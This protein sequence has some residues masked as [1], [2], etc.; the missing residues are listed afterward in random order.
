MRKQFSFILSLVAMLS[1]LVACNSVPD[2]VIPQE[3][4]AQ[5]LADIHI[6]ESV[7]D[8]NSREYMSDSLKKTV[9]QSI[10]LKHDVTQAQLDTSFVWY[11]N[12]I[13]EYMKV[14][15]RVIEILNQRLEHTGGA[16]VAQSVVSIEGDSVDVWS[17][18]RYFSVTSKSPS[19]YLT[20][21]INSDTHWEKGDYYTW[22]VKLLNNMSPI[23]CAMAVDY[24][25]GSTDYTY[26]LVSSEGWNNIKLLSDST[27]SMRRVY[28]YL[29]FNP[30]EGEHLY[31]DSISLVRRRVDSK[32]YPQRFNM[33]PFNY[34]KD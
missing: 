16:T 19:Q 6:G 23:E 26:S 27:K 31:V 10:L 15:E 29:R 21:T 12:N 3:E 2:H 1:I 8:A 4:M 18:S 34:G 24:F 7:V 32:V 9:K 22:N 17:Q 33:M 28:G 11:G 20:F 30:V 13:E 25:D 5:L 14:Y